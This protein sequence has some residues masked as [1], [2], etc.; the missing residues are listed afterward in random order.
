[1]SEREKTRVTW[2]SASGNDFKGC[3]EARCETL[4]EG[5]GIRAPSA[6]SDESSG[7]DDDNLAGPTEPD[8][9]ERLEKCY[10]D[11]SLVRDNKVCS[12]SWKIPMSNE[13]SPISVIWLV[14]IQTSVWDR[15]SV[16]AMQI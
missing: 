7:F 5:P 3:A 10:Y 1:M 13:P 14:D 12:L 6:S 11:D 9:I 2:C 15:G 16:L 8:L 4:Q